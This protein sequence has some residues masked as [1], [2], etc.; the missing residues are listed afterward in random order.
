[1][2]F[3]NIL[4]NGAGFVGRQLDKGVQKA[5]E[6]DAPGKL[7]RGASLVITRLSLG[8]KA[9]TGPMPQ[10]DVGDTE[11]VR[12]IKEEARQARAQ[13]ER[14]LQERLRKARGGSACTSICFGLA[15]LALVYVWCMNE[16]RANTKQNVGVVNLG[17]RNFM[18]GIET[19]E[20][21]TE[22]ELRAIIVERMGDVIIVK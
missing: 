22:P 11:E 7:K 9:A 17:N 21:M 20:P 1:M 13:I 14:D 6:V 2:K 8:W 3:E 15:C 16:S 4:T 19:K 5:S 10:Q 18:L 12:R